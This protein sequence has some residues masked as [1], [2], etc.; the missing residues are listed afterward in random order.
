MPENHQGYGLVRVDSGVTL[1]VPKPIPQL[2]PILVAPVDGAHI[3]DTNIEFKW[4]NVEEANT[5]HLEVRNGN[6]GELVLDL[7]VGDITSSV[8]NSFPNNGNQYNWKVR[9]G[10]ESGWGPWSD[11]KSLVNGLPPVPPNLVSPSNKENVSGTNVEF[12]WTAVTGANEYCLQVTKSIDNTILIDLS[13]GI[14]TSFIYDEFPDTGSNYIWK[15]KAA[16]EVGWGDWSVPISFTNGTAP[17]NPVQ[18]YP[19]NYSII[20]GDAIEFSWS[21]GP[22]G[23]QPTMYQLEVRRGTT[24]IF[25]QNVGDLTSYTLDNFRNNGTGY[26]WRVRAGNEAGWSD[27]AGYNYFRS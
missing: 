22:V 2:A 16:N 1:I 12:V 18:L 20:A 10:N 5:Y 25:N 9:A 19:E 7:V 26:R 21:S 4:K 6:E 27:W 24:I 13:V 23:S 8:H 11:S 17:A 15:V 14:E 3:A